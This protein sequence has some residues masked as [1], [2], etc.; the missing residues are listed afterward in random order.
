[1]AIETLDLE[2]F[3]SKTAN[4]YESIVVASMR[5]RQINDS[6]KLELNQKLE[7]IIAKETEDDTIMNQ[8]KLNISLEFE[9]RQKPTIQSVHE[10]MEDRLNYRFKN[11]KDSE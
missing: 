3:E 9:V 6:M 1:M 4:L 8:D 2:K 10:L 5:S 11:E 7:P